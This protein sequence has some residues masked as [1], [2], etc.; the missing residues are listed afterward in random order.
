MRSVNL[1][2]ELTTAKLNWTQTKVMGRE[3]KLLDLM[4]ELASLSFGDKYKNSATGFYFN[5]RFVFFTDD[6]K[7]NLYKVSSMDDGSE[8]AFIQLT[9][10]PPDGK[11]LISIK[12]GATYRLTRPG[13]GRREW[14]LV[15][16]KGEELCRV[17]ERFHVFKHEGEFSCPEMRPSPIDRL[18]MALIVWY[19]IMVLLGKEAEKG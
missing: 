1:D 4:D 13:K 11:A 18:L 14:A 16:T 10:T 6:P 15:D 8:V 12:G 3:F 7:G 17:K 9:Y 5:R 19:A 2:K